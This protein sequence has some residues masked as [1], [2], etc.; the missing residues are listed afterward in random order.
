M[1]WRQWVDR[2]TGRA[3]RDLE[4]EL[5]AHLDQETE[6][7]REAG[8]PP[9]EARYAAR[10][11][12]GNVTLIRE[13]TRATWGWTVLERFA[14][15]LRYALR[16][17]R[18][19]PGFTAAAV[20]SL[21]LGIGANT[22]IFTFVNAALVKPLPYPHADR[23]VALLQRP[24]H[25]KGT[26]PVHPRS[27]VPWRDRAQSFEALAIAQ[28]LPVNTQGADGA[29]QVSG[30]WMTAELFRVFGVAPFLGRVFTEDEGLNR[31]A[32][33]GESV[34]GKAVV[35]LSH[36]YWQRR[37][38]SDP[39]IQG[40]TMPIGRGSAV[41][42]GVMPAGFRVGALN[43]D[44]YSPIPLD[45]NKPQAV[46][47]R[48]F[49][50]FG[51]LRPGVTLA[52]VQAEMAVI[53]D[54]VARQEPTEKDFGIVVLSLRDYLV[55]DNRL[56][57]LVLLGV[58]AFVL[59][60][61][62]ANLAGL[63]L[64]R[65][66]GRRG[67]LALRASLG[68]SRSRLVQQLL[69]E[70]VA[71]SVLGSSLGLL[72]G[73][74]ASRV[75]VLLAPEAVAF[76]QM[77]DVRLDA[78]VLAF[79]AGLSLLTA[80]L[81]GL[82]PAW[83]LSRFDL[84]GA[85]REHGR[86]AGDSRRQQRLRAALVAGEVALA[87]VLLVGAGL[88]LRTF[89][90]LLDVKLGFQTENVLTMR[91]LILGEPARRSNLVE[92]ILDR[93]ETLPGVLAVGT[94][95]FLPLGGHTNNGPFHFIGRPLPADPMSMESDVSTV[96]RG[97]FLALGIPVL[98]GRPFGRPDG[99]DSP[100]VALVN[101]TFVNKYCPNED[102]IG[103]RIIGD[104]ANPKPT[105]IVGVVGDIRHNGLT[106]EPRPTVFLA[107]AQVPGY[108]TYL[109]VRTGAEPQTLAA[110]IRREIQQVDPNQPMTAV[111]TMDRY[112]SASLARPKLYAVLLGTFAS[113]A[114]LLA[115]I[116]L[117]GL[118][119]YS[120]SRRTHEIGIRMALG[121]QPRDVL[122]STLGEGARLALAGLALGVVCAIALSHFVSN[123]LYGVSAGDPLTYAGVAALLGAVASIAAFLPARRASK[124][125][126]MVALR[127]E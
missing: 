94:I 126:P 77:A 95:Q 103:Q 102:P 69:V 122:R 61:A 93:V 125:D 57:L 118:M 89:S 24:L 40:K 7:Q 30:L 5:R 19:S 76:G 60:I 65:G 84:Q 99:I 96:S 59:L 41:V 26:T 112:V 123:L 1:G 116:G 70:S 49:Q 20:L 117:Y 27:F 75:I 16:T 105:E 43:I 29:E 33:R 4:R 23:I 2:F 63:L 25:G 79:T 111:Q 83:Q 45:R 3:D 106:A 119:A 47:S 64:T 44:V 42:I 50:C 67:E 73:S 78:R 54:Q 81:F 114:V 32:V 86:G 62:C 38:G 92:S 88:L 53:A 52:A 17:M 18:N 34:T 101:Q 14:Q 124:V 68:A 110:A 39:N 113:L 51:L 6:E 9:E 72:L 127:Y 22:A 56:V 48:A 98:R 58:V 13:H 80:L 90:R 82:A 109:V 31:S 46:G 36:G 91:T 107:Q 12:F 15:D 35:V 108:I 100:R 74:W 115:A 21:A 66:I 8:L 85:L 87:V 120:V 97:Y 28:A 104:W 71:L 37:F 10:R 55:R 121:A 11:A